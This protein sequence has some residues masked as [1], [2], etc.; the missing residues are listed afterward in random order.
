MMSLWL[1]IEDENDAGRG[2]GWHPA[3]R[4]F[5][6]SAAQRAAFSEESKARAITSALQLSN[7]PI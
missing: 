3:D 7:A 6:G 2:A 1:T 5:T 4:L